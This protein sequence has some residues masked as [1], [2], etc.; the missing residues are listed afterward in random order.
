MS[1]TKEI[2]IESRTIRITETDGTKTNGQV[3]IVRGPKHDRLSDLINNKDEMF[4]VVYDASVTETEADKPYRVPVTFINKR[5]IKR[6][7]PDETQK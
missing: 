7:T 5:H 3:N 6:A 1:K 4:L 2:E